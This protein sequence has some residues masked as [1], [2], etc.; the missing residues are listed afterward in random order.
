M[1]AFENSILPRI[2][3]SKEEFFYGSKQASAITA[4][5]W[6]PWERPRNATM[7]M[8]VCIGG[9]AGGGGGFTGASA[10][11]RGGGGGGGSG[12]F[13]KLIVPAFFLPK[14]LHL[15]PGNGGK[16]GTGSGV[17]GTV[18]GRSAI[19][20]NPN[21]IGVAANT[22]LVSGAAAAAGGLAGTAAGGQAGG[23]A[24][25]IATN[26]L[27]IYT[28]MGVWTAIAGMAGTAAGALGAAG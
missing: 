2:K 17:A 8:F 18:G 24:E 13:A 7:I 27:G 19:C 22:V 11:A 12:A 10:S 25:T 20:D 14:V 3:G 21:T 15:L 26:L 6:K 23:A 28:G 5:G 9:G 4:T 16:G 1:G